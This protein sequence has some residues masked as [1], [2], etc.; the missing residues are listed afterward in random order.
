MNKLIKLSAFVL[1]MLQV[2]C[3]NIDTRIFGKGMSEGIITYDLSFPYLDDDQMQIANLL[4]DEM[5]YTFTESENQSVISSIGFKTIIHALENSKELNHYVKVL[6][7][8]VKCEYDEGGV[9]RLLST[10]P[11]VHI[12]ETNQ[13]DTLAGVLCK[14]AIGVFSDI[15]QPSMNIYYTEEFDVE[16]PNWCNQF[17]SI[18]GTLMMFEMEQFNLRMRLKANAVQELKKD[19]INF[20]VEDA[21]KDVDANTMNHE[22]QEIFTQ[23]F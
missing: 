2:S 17:A 1:I 22:L 5:I 3:G 21:Y 20:E 23:F 9:D 15:N 8:K 10:Y 18:N 12:V 16:N 13:T 7:K 19:E 4:P 6:S 11:D 14:K